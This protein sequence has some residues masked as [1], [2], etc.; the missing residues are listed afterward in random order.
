MIGPVIRVDTLLPQPAGP[1]WV[2]TRNWIIAGH[3]Q[4]GMAWSLVVGQF[5]AMSEE[6]ALAEA[7]HLNIGYVADRQLFDMLENTGRLH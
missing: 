7:L 2:Y 3:R 5:A 1:G 6:E 4:S